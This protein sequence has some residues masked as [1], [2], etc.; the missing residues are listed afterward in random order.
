[1]YMPSDIRVIS[2]RGL[3]THSASMSLTTTSTGSSFITFLRLRG[4]YCIRSS[5]TKVGIFPRQRRAISYRPNM[6]RRGFSY[7]ED[8][9]RE[10]RISS[11]LHTTGIEAHLVSSDVTQMRA[12]DAATR[13]ST[14]LRRSLI[15]NASGSSSPSVRAHIKKAMIFFTASCDPRTAL[16][17]HMSG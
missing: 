1:M 11:A 4:V 10:F 3:Q 16:S 9:W 2:I 6:I 14:Y 5:V 8:R 12:L 7:L 15:W 17:I 13:V